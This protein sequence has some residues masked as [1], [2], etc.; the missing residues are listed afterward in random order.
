MAD[1]RLID[2]DLELFETL[3]SRGLEE[4]RSPEFLKNLKLV[5]LVLLQ[6]EK[7]LTA[8]EIAERAAELRLEKPS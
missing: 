3:A 8:D 1:D 4:G 5:L 6:A 7:P 2:L